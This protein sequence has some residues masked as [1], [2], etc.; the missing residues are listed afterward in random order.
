MVGAEELIA[1]LMSTLTVGGAGIWTLVIMALAYFAREW[2]ENRKL[3]A[4]EKMARREGYE[5]QLNRFQQHLDAS[6]AQNHAL[7][8]ELR[9]MRAEH[10]AYRRAC[11][12]ETDELRQTHRRETEELR[13]EINQ[14]RQAVEEYKV[15]MAGVSLAMTSPIPSD[16]MVTA[17]VMLDQ[18]R[19]EPRK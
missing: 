11:E 18:P 6:R 7:D 4:D 14:L 8:D 13:R 19:G 16:Q 17:V 1:R 10:T 3:S 2:R 12:R 9:E 5:A 15:K